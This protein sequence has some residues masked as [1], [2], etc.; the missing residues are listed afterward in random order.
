MKSHP[1]KDG[2][3]ELTLKDNE[4]N[5]FCKRVHRIIA[6]VFLE[7]PLNLPVVNHISRDRT[8]NN[9]SNLVWSSI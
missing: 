9:L 3:L 1:N 6:E 5:K 2:Y 4:G 7:N 8:N